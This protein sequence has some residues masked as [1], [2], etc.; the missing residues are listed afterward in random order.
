MQKKLFAIL[1]LILLASM[2]V[3]AFATMT[4]GGT[5]GIADIARDGSEVGG[6]GTGATGAV[7]GSGPVD[8]T[9]AMHEGDTD[10]TGNR[11]AGIIIALIIAAALIAAVAFILQRRRR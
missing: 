1:S 6:M 3:T 9:G 11:W 8:D 4:S 7:D 5:S 10:E 2:A